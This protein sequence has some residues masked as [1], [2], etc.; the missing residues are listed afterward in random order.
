MHA[1][2]L[3][4]PHPA[5]GFIGR[6]VLFVMTVCCLGGQPACVSSQANGIE[7]G[8]DDFG[9]LKDAA[10]T[11]GTQGSGCTQPDVAQDVPDD[12]GRR[13]TGADGSLYPDTGGLVADQTVLD[14]KTGGD[15]V[16]EMDVAVEVKPTPVVLS[17]LAGTPV[18]ASISGSM[19]GV[20]LGEG[21]LGILDLSE[22]PCGSWVGLV[23]LDEACTL[24]AAHGQTAFVL[25]GE[26]TISG[27]D[28]QVPSNPVVVSSVVLD[29]YSVR[30]ILVSKDNLFVLASPLG[31]SA[32]GVLL[33]FD[34]SDA[35]NLSDQW[36]NMKLEGAWIVIP[37]EINIGFVFDMAASPKGD[38]IYVCADRLSAYDIVGNG[39]LALAASYDTSYGPNDLC[40]AVT[41]TDDVAVVSLWVL[42]T[43]PGGAPITGRLD[44]VQADGQLAMLRGFDRDQ[45]SMDL[46]LGSDSLLSVETIMPPFDVQPGS[47]PPLSYSL[48][49]FVV[50]ELL[51]GEGQPNL[52]LELAGGDGV[53][54][55][56]RGGDIALLARGDRLDLLSFGVPAGLTCTILF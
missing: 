22:G 36:T 9:E 32:K 48:T 35:L 8:S 6:Y 10:E 1:L 24:V 54:R 12:S 30:A 43:S 21:G 20:A 3:L 49:R 7:S 29:G 14:A 44:L 45:L 53:P 39:S 16:S 19:A 37:N 47:M 38:R 27:V 50:P 34:A 17:T 18:A 33:T 56:E 46:A 2:L 40:V 4:R 11:C 5:G 31:S 55:L 15:S 13:E 42:L 23:S 28:L 25:S 51:A 26:R 52:T 41:A